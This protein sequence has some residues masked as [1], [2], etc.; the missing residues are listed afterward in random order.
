MPKDLL[1]HTSTSAQ[2]YSVYLA[3]GKVYL[4]AF[5]D[6]QQVKLTLSTLDCLALSKALTAATEIRISEENKERHRTL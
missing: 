1:V 5:A 6:G 3:D 4:M 2:Q